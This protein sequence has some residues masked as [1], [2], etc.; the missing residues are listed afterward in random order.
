VVAIQE[1]LAIASVELKRRKDVAKPEPSMLISLAL[2]EVQK[3]IECGMLRH[4]QPFAVRKAG[5][6]WVLIH[7]ATALDVLAKGF[8]RRCDLRG[9]DI[10]PV[11]SADDLHNLVKYAR[12]TACHMD[13]AKRDLPFESPAWPG[14]S[15]TE[16]GPTQGTIVCDHPFDNPYADDELIIFGSVQI[17]LNRNILA[18]YTWLGE[19]Y[20]EVHFV[21]YTWEKVTGR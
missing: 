4:E 11:G 16:P 14:W 13:S 20:D 19:R 2:W 9:P 21:P 6:T 12:N 17:Y 3:A 7:L 1:L 8:N 10:M 18:C 5:V 15:W